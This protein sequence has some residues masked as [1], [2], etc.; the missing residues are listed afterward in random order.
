MDKFESSDAL[1]TSI[2]DEASNES[3]ESKS[4]NC[5]G[6]DVDM[7]MSSTAKSDKVTT[8]DVEVKS[9]GIDE[10]CQDL[11][12]FVTSNSISSF[13]ISSKARMNEVMTLFEETDNLESDILKEFQRKLCRLADVRKQIRKHAQDLMKS[14]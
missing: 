4:A 1:D 11:K 12:S 6:M 7:E 14:K 5:S 2:E 8:G 3:K 10:M 13:Q 9:L